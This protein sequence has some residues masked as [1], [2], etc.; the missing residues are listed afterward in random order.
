MNFIRLLKIRDTKNRIELFNAFLQRRNVAVAGAA[1][2][3]LFRI[4]KAF[5]ILIENFVK[6]FMDIY[7][8]PVET[9]E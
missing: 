4:N 3:L 9:H 5:K 6:S 8:A 2:F 7:L 1:F